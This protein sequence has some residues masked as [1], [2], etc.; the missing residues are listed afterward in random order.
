[1]S[2]KDSIGLFWE[3]HPQEHDA[4]PSIMP[5]I[6]DTGW[7]PPTFFPDLSGVRVIGLDTETKDLE[8]KTH[9]PGWAR[10]RGHIVGISVA[11]HDASWYFPMRH[12]V[13]PEYNIDPGAVL[14]WA[15]DQLG[16]P[17]QHKVGA[18]LIYDVGWLAEEG[19]E[20]RGP[21][22]DVQNM[23]ALLTENEPV[24]IEYLGQRWLGEGK[25]AEELYRWAWLAYGGKRNGTQR[26]NIW[27]CPPCLAG[28]YAEQ[29]A[30]LPLRLAEL[31][32]PMMHQQGLMDVY[33]METG[34]TPLLVRMRMAGVRVDIPHATRLRDDL[35][36]REEAAI[37]VLAAM[38]GWRLN[39]NSAEEIARAFD[40]EGIPYGRTDKGAPSFRK[41]FLK[42]LDHPL[43]K[44][45]M[46][47]RRLD[48][49]RST[50]VEGYVLGKNVNGR[51]YG[52]FHQL[53][54]TEGGARSGR[55]ASSDPNLQNLPIRDEEL[56]PLIRACF[57]KEFDHID[58]AK[59]D[60]SQIEY[61]F[62][63][64]FAVGRGSEE[65]RQRYIANPETDY[66]D[67]THDIV[68]EITGQ[69]IKRRPI[70]NINFGLI[71]GMGE[72]KLARDLGLSK[73]EGQKLFRFYHKALPFAKATMEAAIKEAEETGLVKT[74]MG[75]ISRFEF[76]QPDGRGGKDAVG[77]PY[78]QALAAYGQDITMAYTHKALNRKL[79]GSAAD[80]MKRAMLDCYLSGAFDV[81]IPRLTVHDELDFS[82]PGTPEG[83][84]ALREIKWRMENAIP[85][86]IPV[87]AE[88]DRGEHWG[89][90]G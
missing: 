88:V 65:L 39:V 53:R 77:L 49:L 55:F 56:G 8:L 25:E 67:Y 54:G 44:Q 1:M 23:A 81:L 73:P 14:A 40:A 36:Q 41:D 22:H 64:H 89:A 50:F 47:V 45:I 2:R 10:K 21:L 9:G 61:R 57:V 71:Y 27:R 69:D 52:S 33:D 37:D 85:L 5:P 87:L 46:E 35:R 86:R 24:N 59:I 74:I 75:R 17:H 42:A 16:R 29:D 78:A 76:Y 4:A 38:T 63:A 13:Q 12:E 51:L 58:W 84:E 31:F 30:H 72:D 82:M 28:P 20:V 70:K 32:F 79:Q 66:H 43:A 48:K 11:T 19:V 3:D 34:L 80:A 60:L 68:H 83:E 90:C 7:R 62:L 26:A 15:R 6:P 18:N